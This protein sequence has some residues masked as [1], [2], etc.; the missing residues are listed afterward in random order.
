MRILKLLFTIVV[1]LLGL[2]NLSAQQVYYE[3]HINKHFVGEHQCRNLKVIDLRKDKSCIGRSW[4]SSKWD[5]KPIVTKKPFDIVLQDAYDKMK[6]SSKLGDDE[7]VM[8]LYDFEAIDESGE[9]DGGVATLFISADFFRGNNGN[10]RF[11]TQLNTFYEMFSPRHVTDSLLTKTTERIVTF[12]SW[13]SVM[14]PDK[15]DSK[16]YSIEQLA[17]KR[18]SIKRSSAIYNASVYPKGIYYTWEQFLNNTPVDTPFIRWYYYKGEQTINN[19]YFLNEKGKRG[20]MIPANTYVAISDGKNIW[21]RD[22]MGLERMT[23]EDGDFYMRKHY[24]HQYY[25]ADV[26]SIIFTFGVAVI[27]FYGHSSNGK[28]S[29]GLYKARFD[30]FTKTFIPVELRYSPTL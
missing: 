28:I 29:L 4:Q 15:S 3:M 5:K 18:A 30:P 9:Y 7:L 24:K 11:V 21:T 12:F 13:Y 14:M 22:T 2:Q 26:N 17:D 19:F 27:A 6:D 1:F 25:T 10:Y 20:E 23:F 16:L 8:V